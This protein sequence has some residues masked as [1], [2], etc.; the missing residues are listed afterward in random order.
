M[1]AA[2]PQRALWPLVLVLSAAGILVGHDLSY[3]L[4]GVGDGGIHA[5]L[6]HAPQILLALLVPAVLVSLAASGVA[7]RPVAFALLGG[8]GFTLMEHFER[9]V[10]G[11]LPWLLTSPVFLLGLALQVPFALAAWWLATTLAA[12]PAPAPR[13]PRLV[14][15]FSACVPPLSQALLG[16]GRDAAPRSRAPPDPL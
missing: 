11:E 8:G 6:A 5:Y 7:P 12:L 13:L 10:H 2:M 16:R 9:A 15:R 4:A 3:R 14:P 1:L